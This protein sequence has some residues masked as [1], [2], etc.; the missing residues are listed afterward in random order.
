MTGTIIESDLIVDGNISSP[1]GTISV[2]GRVTGDISAKALDV[3][4]GGHVNGSVQAD[5]VSIHGE[6]SGSVQ[7]A[8]LSL[9]ANS[10][11]S[12][13]I[14]AETMVSEKGAKLMGEVKITG[15]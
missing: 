2:K 9:G 7:C 8:E 13:K 15:G 12:S 1:Q 14:V 6:Q 4:S 11:V 10:Q 5:S 3:A